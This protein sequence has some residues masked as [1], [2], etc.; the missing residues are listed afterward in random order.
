MRHQFGQNYRITD[1]WKSLV[2]LTDSMQQCI[3]KGFG[4]RVDD[5]IILIVPSNHQHMVSYQLPSSDDL[6]KGIDAK[7]T[8]LIESWNSI[9]TLTNQPKVL[10]D[11]IQNDFWSMLPWLKARSTP[12]LI[13][14]NATSRKHK[15]R[16][17]IPLS[18]RLITKFG[19]MK[20]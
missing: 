10:A 14:K 9:N 15:K 11:L 19:S 12:P 17:Y 3:N 20:S 4:S 7:D 8:T 13:R 2:G 6:K 5:T 1:T 18:R 16:K